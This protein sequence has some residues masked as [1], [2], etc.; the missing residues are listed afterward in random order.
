MQV[1]RTQI[2]DLLKSRGNDT[3][4]DVAEVVFPETVDTDDEAFLLAKFRIDPQDLKGKAADN[5]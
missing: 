5:Q 1:D 4:T 3:L 2:I